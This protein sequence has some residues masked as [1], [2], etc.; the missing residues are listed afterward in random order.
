MSVCPNCNE[1]Y[2][3]EDYYD[4]EICENCITVTEVCSQKCL[5]QHNCDTHKSIDLV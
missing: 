5:N 3:I 2:T 4:Y 1:S